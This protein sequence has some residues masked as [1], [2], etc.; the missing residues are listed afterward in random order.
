[1]YNGFY[2][3]LQQMPNM[4]SNGSKTEKGVG[5]QPDDA[6]PDRGVEQAWVA[7]DAT[8]NEYTNNGFENKSEIS[9]AIAVDD[10][11]QFNSRYKNKIEEKASL[12]GF[13]PRRPVLKTHEIRDE[14]AEWQY[15]G[16]LTD[17]V[18]DLLKIQNVLNIHVSITNITNQM[19][20]SYTDGSGPNE[21]LSRS[22]LHNEIINYYHVVSV[23]DYLEQYR[24]A[25]WGT[26]NVLLDDFEGKDN[27][28]WRRVGE[29]SNQ[30][31]VVPQGDSTYPIL[32]LADLTMDYLKENTDSWEKKEIKKTLI[33]VTPDDSAFVSVTGIHTPEEL[34]KL[35]PTARR[36]IDR[37]QHYPHPI[38]FIDRGG[39]KRKELSNYE[40]YHTVADFV[41]SERGCMKYFNESEDNSILR[42]ED[43]ILCLGSAS[44]D[45]YS[46]FERYNN[47]DGDIVLSP[48]DAFERFD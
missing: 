30:L 44:T 4:D 40:I 8:S 6:A 24:D 12:Y 15:D 45:E 22:N 19:I 37:S 41:H 3:C 34:E 36:N 7:S 14:A 47:S 32:S 25:P 43:F 10:R 48:E 18:E 17:F 20:E 13:S 39:V 9:I 21:Q 28:P 16:I 1:M 23:W 11:D 31:N 29:M 5:E 46:Q 33:D 2:N 27:Y 26:T 35:V 38:V 42:S